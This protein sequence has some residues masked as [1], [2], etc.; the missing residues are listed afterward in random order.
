MGGSTTSGEEGAATDAAASPEAKEPKEA[1]TRR[2]TKD[3]SSQSGAPPPGLY[4]LKK[5]ETAPPTYAMGREDLAAAM[6]R[7][8]D[9][10]DVH[11]AA[12][13]A[14]PISFERQLGLAVREVGKEGFKAMVAKWDH[15]GKGLKMVDCKPAQPLR[16]RSAA[17]PPPHEAACGCNSSAPA[18]MLPGRT[19]EW[20]VERQ[21]RV[22]W[23]CCP[24]SPLHR[25]RPFHDVPM[26][27]RVLLPPCALV[28]HPSRPPEPHSPSKPAGRAE[29]RGLQPRH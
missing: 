19:C 1:T 27:P 25:M 16:R 23:S 17:A 14:V 3:D 20:P 28:P 7:W 29:T 4:V 13:A 12:A 18:H 21:A 9:E 15:D 26:L 24:L 11:D 2:P 8:N 5:G 6:Q 22:A 10:A